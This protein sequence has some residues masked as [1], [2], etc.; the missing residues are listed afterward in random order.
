MTTTT[1]N[2]VKILS[3]AKAIEM[4]ARLDGKAPYNTP[5]N[6]CWNDAYY[7]KSIEREFGMTL[8]ELRKAV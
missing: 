3:K 5:S 1:A 4:L 7:A 2:T 8:K 6:I